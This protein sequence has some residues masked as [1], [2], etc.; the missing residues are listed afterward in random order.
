FE[1]K[2]KRTQG[3]D[4]AVVTNVADV[5]GGHNKVSE[6]KQASRIKGFN[7][8]FATASIEAAKRYYLEF[9]KQQADLL[10]DQRLKV[11]TIFSYAANE[12]VG[13]DYLDEEGFET[14]SLDQSSRDFLDEAIK[15]YNKL[16]GT[17]Y[18]TSA[19]KFHN[20]Y[21]DL[22]LRLKNREIDLV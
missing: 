5:V 10:P 3:Y 19:D 17:S 9:K 4:Y 13:D 11:A 12:D 16:F 7:A 2:T 22:S 14:S 18:D 15:D 21:K 1:Q 6:L 20:Y 8:I